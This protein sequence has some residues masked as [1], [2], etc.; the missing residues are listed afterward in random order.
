MVTAIVV[1]YF[2]LVMALDFRITVK[3]KKRNEIWIYSTCLILGFVVLFLRSLDIA[4][5]GPTRLIVDV[6][7]KLSLV[8]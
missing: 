3:S 5:P 7:K 8:E 2:T 4:V 1:I 6:L